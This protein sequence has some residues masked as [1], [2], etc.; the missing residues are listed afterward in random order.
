MK[1]KVQ[2]QGRQYISSES[3]WVKI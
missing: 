2:L 3:I 1:G